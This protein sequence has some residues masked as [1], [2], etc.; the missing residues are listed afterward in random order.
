M[1]KL[2]L[3]I[4]LGFSIKI[5]GE[6]PKFI[7]FPQGITFLSDHI[8][9]Y[10]PTFDNEADA[11]NGRNPRYLEA[12]KRDT[13]SLMNSYR[14]TGIGTHRSDTRR[15]AFSIETPG[16]VQKVRDWIHQY[17]SLIQ[18]L[19][20]TIGDYNV[21]NNPTSPFIREDEAFDEDE[22]R[23]YHSPYVTLSSEQFT[24]EPLK[25]VQ[26]FLKKHTGGGATHT[27]YIITEFIRDV[28]D[29]NK[30]VAQKWVEKFPELKS[31]GLVKP[32]E[33]Y[34]NNIYK[35]AE[36][37]ASKIQATYRGYKV[38]K[39]RKAMNQAAVKLQAAARGYVAR[40]QFHKK[41]ETNERLR[42]LPEKVKAS[43]DEVSN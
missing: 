18:R 17:A 21:M 11:H 22:E 35:N 24:E 15:K 41:S 19:G 12:F 28:L 36:S 7:V 34:D 2:I 6:M 40:N 37:A 39:D 42:T 38:R 5:F 30:A 14:W 32:S 25:E 26:A 29:Y 10:F 3:C 23:D 1:K 8:P 4:V 33:I 9:A 43:L 27:R 13:E 31:Q 16:I 20:I